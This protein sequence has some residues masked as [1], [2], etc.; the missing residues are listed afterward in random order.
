MIF[1]SLQ[2]PKR[3]E[4]VLDLSKQYSMLHRE[5]PEGDVELENTRAPETK[6]DGKISLAGG[7][8]MASK[9]N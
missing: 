4:L 6:K 5:W 8:K 7:R 1:F 9:G 3:V 2:E